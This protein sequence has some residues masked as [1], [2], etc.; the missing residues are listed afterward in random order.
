MSASHVPDTPHRM[1]VLIDDSEDDRVFVKTLIEKAGVKN[2][3]LP[4]R[5]GEEAVWLRPHLGNGGMIVI[6]RRLDQERLVDFTEFGKIAD[7][8]NGGLD[9]CMSSG[10]DRETVMGADVRN[11]NL[12]GHQL[13]DRNR[14]HGAI[15]G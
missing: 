4:M 11:D 8:F 14:E 13:V 7:A 9:Q 10:D 1:I 2:E 3:V 5:G 12:P 6:R 15:A